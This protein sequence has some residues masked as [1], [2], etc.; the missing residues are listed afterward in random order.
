MTKHNNVSLI[1]LLVYCLLIG[2]MLLALVF[3]VYKV[4]KIQPYI[5]FFMLEIRIAT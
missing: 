5:I 2:L 4:Q 1:A 3:S